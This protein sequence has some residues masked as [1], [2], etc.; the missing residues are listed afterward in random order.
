MTFRLKNRMVHNCNSMSWCYQIL[1]KKCY[2][3]PFTLYQTITT[4]NKPFENIMSKGENAGNQH[5]V[6]SS[7]SFSYSAV[8]PFPTVFSTHLESFLPFS[9]NLKLS[10]ANS[11]SM[12]ESKILC[13]GKG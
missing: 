2:L 9:S 11:F 10:S 12:E 7:N 13:L 8:S 1:D 5:F 6:V 4:L 3:W